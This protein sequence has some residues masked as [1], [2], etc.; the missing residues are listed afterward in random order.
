MR[1]KEG[2]VDD[3]ITSIPG[4]WKFD[5][6]VSQH[7]DTHVRKSV[8]LYEEVQKAVIEISEWFIRDN[9]VVYDLGSSTGETI[10]LLLQKHSR[11]KNVR[12][13]GVEESLPMIEIARKKCSSE[14][15]QFLQQHIEE[16]NEFANID[17]VLSLY[18]LQF[19]PLWKRKKVLQRIY[20]GLV[21]GGAFI[22]VEKIRA[23]NSLFED[24][25]N[26]LYWDFKQENGLNEQQSYKKGSKFERRFDSIE[27]YRE[28]E[29]TI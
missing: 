6:Q 24:I 2:L 26:D 7:F 9:S 18:T 23:E 19:L 3:L 28:F 21:E 29:S 27:S 5:E 10:S 12:F 17:L 15:V 13:I 8:P 14:L 25:W 4:E 20:N 11:K 16:I 1:N 22:F